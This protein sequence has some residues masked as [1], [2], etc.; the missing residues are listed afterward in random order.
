MENFINSSKTVKS[1]KFIH[2][3]FKKYEAKLH[4]NGHPRVQYSINLEL[5]DLLIWNFY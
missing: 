5:H 4:V 3:S 1:L 2:D